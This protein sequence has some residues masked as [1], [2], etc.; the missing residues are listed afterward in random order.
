MTETPVSSPSSIE[1]PPQYATALD[2]IVG[3]F[4]APV[5]TMRSI[6]AAPEWLVPMLLMLVLA[7]VGSFAAA[8]QIDMT[9]EMRTAIEK[10]FEG[11]EMSE[12]QKARIEDQIAGAE[13]FSKIM[14][15]WG[16]LALPLLVLV[17]AGAL[18]IAFSMFGGS[19][20]FAQAFAI[21]TY[22]WIPLSAKSLIASAVVAMR[23]DP[24]TPTALAAASYTNLAFLVD[25]DHSRPLFMLLSAFDLF[26]F[27][28]LVLLVL[29]FSFASGLSRRASAIIIGSL[30][31]VTI[32]LRVVPALF[33]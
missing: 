20:R 33:Q 19:S 15:Q 2:R 4:T 27:W 32:L 6:A 10:R 28:C 11:Q 13:K 7:A 18:Q 29:G 22:S 12:Q 1:P 16:W 26:T 9:T 25:L 3:V 5:Q 14:F 30:W 23:D 8:P 21:V 17:L 31:V 24:T